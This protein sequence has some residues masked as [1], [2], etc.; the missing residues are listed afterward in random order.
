MD[1][2][3]QIQRRRL[4]LEE[5]KQIGDFTEDAVC[6]YFEASGFSMFRFGVEHIFPDWAGVIA[7]DAY[8]DRKVRGASD[9]FEQQQN[10]TKFLRS[11]P[12]FV[13]IRTAPSET[14]VREI[15]P[16]EVKFRTE[17]VFP[18]AA[19]P[20]HFI[21][22]SD[23]SVAGYGKHWPSTLLVVVCY[24]ART[25]IATR[26]DKLKKVPDSQVLSRRPTTARAGFTTS[27]AMGSARFGTSSKATSMLTLQPRR[28][29]VSSRL[30]T[31]WR[32]AMTCPWN[33]G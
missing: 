15:F 13:A 27:R 31:W 12:D 19:R 6:A 30:L 7:D 23:D 18:A 26:I 29:P 25:M 21:R 10:L 5:N 24:H 1:K 33:E 22:L 16:V 3:S 2:T 20:S 28:S 11:F 4:T 32:N 8:A 9:I 17:R 14:G